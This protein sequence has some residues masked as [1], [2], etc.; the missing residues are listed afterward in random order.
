MKV[1]Y[2]IVM[3]CLI[4]TKAQAAEG[5][6]QQYN[7]P[8]ENDMNS[9]SKSCSISTTTL[10][11]KVN[12]SNSTVLKEMFYNG[13]EKT[14]ALEN[15]KV[16]DADSWVC[17]STNHY[18]NNRLGVMQSSMDEQRMSGGIFVTSLIFIPNNPNGGKNKL[19]S[20][21]KKKSLFGIF[22]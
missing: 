8:T 1:L 10:N 7:C 18:G 17:G 12:P 3:I 2:L 20:C 5:A 19:F 16:V 22:D 14:I 6:Y 4:S 11:F 15:C 21:A 9:C 13:G